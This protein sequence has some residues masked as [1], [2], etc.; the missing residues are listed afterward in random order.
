[1]Q[2]IMQLLKQTILEFKK[3]V[4]NS[5]KPVLILFLIQVLLRLLI[6]PLMM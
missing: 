3:K 6:A 5:I 4:F 1:M 2:L